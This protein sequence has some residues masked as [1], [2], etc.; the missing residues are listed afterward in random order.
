MWSQ[1]K[2]K[3]TSGI[4][5]YVIT[6]LAFWTLFPLLLYALP[7]GEEAASVTSDNVSLLLCGIQDKL[8]VTAVCY[9]AMP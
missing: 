5:S 2:S 7:S 8:V 1:I 9:A 6:E 4:I 3:G